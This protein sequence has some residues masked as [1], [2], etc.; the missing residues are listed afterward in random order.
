MCRLFGLTAGAHRVRSTFWLLD[1]PDS[2]LDQSRRNP[3]GCG[4][5]GFTATGEVELHKAPV[6]AFDDPGFGTA[7]RDL[8]SATFIAHVRHAS[9]GANTYQNTHPFVDGPVAFAH[10]GALAGL[11]LLE[12]HLGPA[13]GRVHGDTDSE[14][15]FALILTE[16]A[17]HDGDLGAGIT[18][19]VRWL[20]AH[21]PVLS[22]N[23]ILTTPAALWALRYPAT[24]ELWILPR[25]AGGQ[26]G[27]QHL[28]GTG[29]HGGI[30]VHSPG[31]RDRPAV[32]VASERLD[33]HPDWQL[34]APGEL[35]H[36]DIGLGVRRRQ[37]LFQPPV[38]PCA[39]RAAHPPTG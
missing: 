26:H 2:L 19:A 20:A 33:D 16:T 10:N 12:A 11:D 13:M 15:M 7:A 30:R 39:T 24:D 35:V 36:V 32:V 23:L 17:A 29:Q 21:V 18:A 1:A 6:A 4:I 27:D 28:H 9:T 22:L 34:L 37:V 3:D 38:H 25:P 5:A 14:P 31:L 8:V